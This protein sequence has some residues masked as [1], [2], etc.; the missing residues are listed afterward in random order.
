MS[1][2]DFVIVRNE[3][4]QERRISRT[5]WNL[6][7][8]NSNTG[9]TR[10]GWTLIGESPE[11]PKG[12]VPT[13]ADRAATFI[14][15]EIREAQAKVAEQEREVE[16]SMISGSPVGPLASPVPETAAP[17][18]AAAVGAGDNLATIEGIGPK[19]AGILNAAGIGT[20][21]DLASA[22]L[23]T[24]NKALDEAGMGPKKALTPSWKTKAAELAKK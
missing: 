11:K 7:R 18:A 8:N 15:D 16:T 1:M 2:A 13:S 5:S 6:L 10:K 14:P 9:N 22:P 3:K 24:I 20:F 4:G 19:V 12:S 17:V 23:T 21:K